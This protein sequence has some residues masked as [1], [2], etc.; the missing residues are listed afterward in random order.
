MKL[1]EKEAIKLAKTKWWEKKEPREVVEFQLQQR[2]CMDFS[3]FHEL[4]EKV[5][6]RPVFTHEFAYPDLL[7]QELKGERKKASFL[8]VLKKIPS[9]HDVT[10]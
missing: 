4:T 3:K 2:L 8:D 10:N 1:S 6:E 7:L 5:L 9:D